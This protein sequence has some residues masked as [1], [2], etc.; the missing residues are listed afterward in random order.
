MLVKGIIEDIAIDGY[1]AKVRVPKI[2]R[3]ASDPLGIP[4]EE[5]DDATIISIPGVIP[6]Y[7]IGDVV[8]VQFEDDEISEIEGFI[9][10][11][12]KEVFI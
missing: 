11:K 8:F 1:S 12:M 2:H 9:G 10:M 3:V 4:T 7:K 6:V 5:L